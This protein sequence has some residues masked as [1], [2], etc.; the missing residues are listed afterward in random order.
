MKTIDKMIE[1][2]DEE[3]EGAREYAEKYIE[4]K[5]RGHTGRAA[6]YKEMAFDE[7]KHAETVYAFAEEDVENIRKVH[8]LS[9]DEEEL[10]AH[11]KKKMYEHIA[12]IKS[13]LT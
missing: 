11:A 2:I 10:W 3:V 4:C 13:Y 9:V 1:H 5:S 8:P 12:H 7:L 6:K